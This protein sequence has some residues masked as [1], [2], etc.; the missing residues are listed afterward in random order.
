MK[1][2]LNIVL[3]IAILAG[4][5]Y[6]TRSLWLSAPT[7]EKGDEIA[8]GNSNG[9]QT[10]PHGG[11]ILRADDLQLEIAIYEQGVAPEFRVYVMRD[12]TVLAPTETMLSIRASR[13]GGQVDHFRFAARDNY[14]A[15]LETVREPHSFDV[16]ITAQLSDQRYD[17]SYSQYEGR[18]R[19]PIATAT[20][21]GIEVAMA[22][23]A[24][25]HEV[26]QLQGQVRADPSRLRKIRPRY[27]GIIRAAPKRIGE[28]VSRGDV[29]ARIESNDSLQTYEVT[30]PINGIIIDQH[31]AAGEAVRD[32]SIY[33]VANLE[34]LMVDL[35]VFPRDQERIA[36][37]QTVV[38]KLP[39]GKLETSAKIDYL[40]PISDR[41]SQAT[42]ARITID[43][44]QGL[45]RPGMAVTA[46]VTVSRAQVPLAV[47]NTAIQKFRDFDVVYA[48][49]G[50]EYEVRM[51]QLGRRDSANTSVI[52]GLEAG[53]EYVT[54][55]SYMLKADI[56][57]SGAVHAH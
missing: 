35:A 42:K 20:A 10:G 26:V 9:G 1:T 36:A 24:E 29:L 45:W 55:N 21:A 16:D 39:G 53:T 14:L 57:K 49:Y 7:I 8:N 56:E 41:H 3:T 28:S 46:E 33:T 52:S 13:L 2:L 19:I 31:A 43:N 30:A 18:V 4:G 37:G 23:P 54:A 12:G 22:G 38:L 50:E 6:S 5:A 40:L 47:R 25:I 32:Q 11:R 27:A 34:K 15:S 17:W 48:R 51:L 44:A